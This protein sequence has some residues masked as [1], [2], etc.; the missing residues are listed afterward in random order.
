MYYRYV[1]SFYLGSK[2]AYDG[3]YDYIISP[4]MLR[5]SIAMGKDP[6]YINNIQQSQYIGTVTLY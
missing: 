5:F 4:F 2:G 6:V 3:I 1:S